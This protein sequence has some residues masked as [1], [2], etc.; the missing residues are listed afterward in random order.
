[1][2]AALAL[3]AGDADV[4]LPI[5]TFNRSVLHLA[6][7]EGHLDLLR[8]LIEG[9]ADV[10]AAD[11]CGWT[12][13]H[14]AARGNQVESID[15]LVEA[16]A[17]IEALENQGG[18]PPYDV[19]IWRKL[20]TLL[21]LL[22]HGADVNPRDSHRRTPLYCCACNARVQRITAG[23]VACLLRAA[24]DETIASLMTKKKQPWMWSWSWS[25]RDCSNQLSIFPRILIWYVICW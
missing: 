1:M 2:A 5:G 4:S 11:E 8:A 21:A 7:L 16:G 12:P 17:S 18:P 22:K 19:A 13:L 9:G 23:V 14:A 25:A 3:V 15:A 10:N 24:A 20:E 6:A